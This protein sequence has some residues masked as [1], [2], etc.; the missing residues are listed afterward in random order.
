MAA[1]DWQRMVVLSIVSFFF[2]FTPNIVQADVRLALTPTNY[3]WAIDP[4]GTLRDRLVI[5]NT[6]NEAIDLVIKIYRFETDTKESTEPS[7]IAE[8]THPYQGK[9]KIEPSLTKLSLAKRE[10]RDVKLQL[11]ADAKA[12][13]GTYLLAIAVETVPRETNLD[14]DAPV[15]IGQATISRLIVPAVIL[16]NGITNI[17]GT[18]EEFTTDKS[19]YSTGP[20][21]FN[22]KF[23]NPGLVHYA[24]KATIAILKDGEILEN[25]EIE[26]KT[27][28]PGHS[29]T[30]TQIWNKR[31]LDNGTY[32]AKAFV[33]YG[34]D[35]TKSE[36]AATTF[37][38]SGSLIQWLG[39]V[40]GTLAGILVL[41]KLFGR[42]RKK[43]RRR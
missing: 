6:G 27:V 18:I 25:F 5:E 36:S 30:I 24:A 19:V 16:V 4:G 38:V 26:P 12:K 21:Q 2:A 33:A 11:S 7:I 39:P 23:S 22:L 17:E 29:R 3:D 31:F 43:K 13:P 1:R 42:R 20:V 28:L 15:G 10:S 37:R 9:V 35:Y 14:S 41:T 32:E 34:T 8:D 40:T